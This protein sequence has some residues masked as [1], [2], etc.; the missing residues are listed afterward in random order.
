[1]SRMDGR[2]R[3]SIGA[4]LTVVAVLAFPGCADGTE[5][6]KARAD[7]A[8]AAPLKMSDSTGW[9]LTCHETLTPGAVAAWRQS[10]HA[11]T[12]PRRALERPE[13]ERRMSSETVP[14]ELA[15]VVVGCYECHGLRPDKHRDSVRHNGSRISVV[16]SPA[17]C[18][19][20]HSVEATQFTTS[21]KAFALANLTE[22]PVF[23][24][25]MHATTSMTAG[26]PTTETLN[27]T[28]RACHGAPIE[29]T[30]FETVQRG[31][32]VL[33]PVLTNWPNQ[34]VGRINPDG[35][36][37]ACTACHPRHR[38]AVSTARQAH[39]C[40]QCHL[41]PDFPAW[42]VWRESKHGNIVLSE[43]LANEAWNAMPWEPGK[44]FTAP[45]CAVCHV[46]LLVDVKGRPLAR[47]SHD[48]GSRLWVRLAGLP[49][50]HPQPRGGATY[51]LRNA[52][53]QPL[54]TTFDGR[55]AGPPGLIDGDEQ[56]ERRTAMTAIC[57]ACH[58]TPWARGHF[59]RLD[60]TVATTNEAT[61][62][63]TVLVQEAWKAGLAHGDQPFDEP[64]E[65]R[66][67]RQWLYY[68]TS[69]RYGAAM[70]GP[71]YSTFKNGW[72]DLTAN[73][74]EMATVLEALRATAN[75]R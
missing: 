24:K 32:P 69:T 30:G 56:V 35:T 31:V 15:D 12:T 5:P 40:S 70:S 3:S 1:M 64:I 42:N 54:P 39:T 21:K 16:M 17:D 7:T 66:W 63:A 53:G 71:D 14:E 23:T 9:C 51:E 6:P 33:L 52:D 60:A 68:A 50:A 43:P 28:C 73:H 26:V 49:A 58:A 75:R 72:A 10:A 74:R 4:V 11:R 41:E 67:V 20:C 57:T 44:H 27:V 48:L 25:L 2:L 19:V 61:G 46:S 55:P 37:G 62:K 34:G 8:G 36:R 47:R 22:N 65:R 59:D 45:T 13:L 18:A 38:F 29:V